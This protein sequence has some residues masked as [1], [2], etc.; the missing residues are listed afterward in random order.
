MNSPFNT[1]AAHMRGEKDDLFTLHDV[2][3]LLGVYVKAE[4]P[5]S[6]ARLAAYITDLPRNDVLE[7]VEDFTDKIV[8]SHAIHDHVAEHVWVQVIMQYPAMAETGIL[9]KTTK[10]PD[11][12][13]LR[14]ALAEGRLDPKRPLLLAPLDYEESE[15]FLNALYNEEY[16]H[17]KIMGAGKALMKLFDDI[18]QDLH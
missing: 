9:E 3:L 15:V 13:A 14:D 11:P 12:S 4:M 2:C 8:W 7:L 18:E 16:R 17:E 6:V 10:L 1:P 5:D